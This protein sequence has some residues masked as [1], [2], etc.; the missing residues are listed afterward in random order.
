MRHL[1]SDQEGSAHYTAAFT[2][3]Q[4]TTGREA[5]LRTLK[6]GTR[7]PVPAKG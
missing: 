7:Q 1:R 4:V 6:A 2:E 3:A 5:N